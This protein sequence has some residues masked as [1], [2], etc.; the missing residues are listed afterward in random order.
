[1]FC[2]PILQDLLSRKF[3]HLIHPPISQDLVP[4]DFHVFRPLKG[5]TRSEFAEQVCEKD[6]H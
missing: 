1:M 5:A 4:S 3:E 2:V 6:L